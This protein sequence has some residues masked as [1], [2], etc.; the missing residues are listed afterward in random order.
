MYGFAFGSLIA[1]TTFIYFERQ[2]FNDV[3]AET[4][5]I[6]LLPVIIQVAGIWLVIKAI[7]KANEGYIHVGRAVFSGIITS[8]VMA[9]VAN[10]FFYSY[11]NRN[12]MAMEQ[13][14][15]SIKART[16]N[17]ANKPENAN[18]LE[19]DYL[20]KRYKAIDGT[21]TIKNHMKGDMV[22][23]L[24]IGLVMSISFGMMLQKDPPTQA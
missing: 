20:G 24:G 6:R 17:F 19:E 21:Y 13:L 15:D 9:I 14:K 3:V 7:R 23:Y 8:V 18:K 2:M 12:P 10:V 1:L 4:I 5:L 11:V 22:G 16:L